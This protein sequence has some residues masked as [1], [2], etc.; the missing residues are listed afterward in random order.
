MNLPKRNLASL[1]TERASLQHFTN[2]W[3]GR[4]SGYKNKLLSIFKQTTQIRTLVAVPELT[5]IVDDDK[6]RR[7]YLTLFAFKQEKS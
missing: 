3:L 2:T 4:A 7:L 6:I 1:S 5:K